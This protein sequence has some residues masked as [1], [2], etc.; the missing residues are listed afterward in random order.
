MVVGEQ[1]LEG[2]AVGTGC[3]QVGE[4]LGE[5]VEAPVE[6]GRQTH[7]ACSAASPL[8]VGSGSEALVSFQMIFGAQWLPASSS[9]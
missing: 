3:G 1:W 7:V 9:G 5:G 6:G 8:W 2:R 4:Q